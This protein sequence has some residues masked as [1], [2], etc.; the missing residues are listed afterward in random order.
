MNL[1]MIDSDMYNVF[2][3]RVSDAQLSMSGKK[4]VTKW[5]VKQWWCNE[6]NDNGQ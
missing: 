3:I 6:C 5:W 2:E 4:N 1:N